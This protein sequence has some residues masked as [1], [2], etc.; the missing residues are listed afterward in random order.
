MYSKRI[1]LKLEYRYVKK[2]AILVNNIKMNT[3][4]VVNV[5]CES[6]ANTI[7]KELSNIWISDIEIW[8]WENDSRFKRKLSFNWSYDFAKEKL[9]FLWY[10][11]VWTKE[12]ES[13]LKKAKSFISCA[14]WKI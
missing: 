14:K 11:E 13:I 12:A 1:Q 7:K 10:P 4:Y 6:C 8:F 9:N 2:Y 3:I 5:K